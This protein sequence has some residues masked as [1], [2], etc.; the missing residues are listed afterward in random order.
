[1]TFDNQKRRGIAVFFR[2]PYP[3]YCHRLPVDWTLW[4]TLTAKGII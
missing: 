2:S 1:M 4:R 3:H